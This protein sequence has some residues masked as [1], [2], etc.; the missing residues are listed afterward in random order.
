MADHENSNYAKKSLSQLLKI[1]VKGSIS[2]V[3][4]LVIGMLS[5]AKMA[6]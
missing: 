4:A 5:L 3:I 6:H 1:S 2:N